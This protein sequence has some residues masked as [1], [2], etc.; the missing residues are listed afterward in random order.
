MEEILTMRLYIDGCSLTYGQGLP[1]DQSLGHL[2]TTQG[3]YEVFDASRPGKSNTAICMDTHKYFKDY[4]VFV[5]AS[6]R[7][8]VLEEVAR[9]FD[10]MKVFGDTAASYAAFVRAMKS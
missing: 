10:K 8:Q 5:L 9:E 3:G 4:D 7:N 6:Q 1:R 2:F